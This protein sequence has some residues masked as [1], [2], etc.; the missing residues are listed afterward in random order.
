MPLTYNQLLSTDMIVSEIEALLDWR[1]HILR[2]SIFL[3][4]QVRD[5]DINAPAVLL[6]WCRKES[7]K[8]TVDKRIYERLFLVYEELCGT[9]RHILEGTAGRVPLTLSLYDRF[10]NQFE[11]YITQ[12]RRLHQDISDMAVAVDPVT[13]LRT[14]AG[15]R[16]DLLRE[17]NRFDRKGTS[18]S[19][20]S[21]EIDRLEKLQKAVDRKNMDIV[22]TSV[23][24]I[25]ARTIR[26]FD[27]VY[28]LGKGEYV[29]ILKHVEFMDA[30]AVM[31]RRSVSTGS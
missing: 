8:G 14:V 16:G 12:I 23:G 29:V 28:F 6:T 2:Q 3:G 10:E 24:Q 27:D 22:Y 26:S 7:E 4:A 20:A 9:A 11:G 31:D 18:Y 1:H 17:Q 19:I 21:V 13:G 5:G 15:M 30:C 25:I